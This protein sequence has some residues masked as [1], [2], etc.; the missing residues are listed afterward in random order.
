VT[1]YYA[2]PGIAIYHGDAREVLPT[3]ERGLMVT[4]PPYNVG[5]HYD[6]HE[7]SLQAED[8]RRLLGDVL[9]MPLVVI[10]YPEALV[11]LAQIFRRSADEIVAWVYHAHTPRKWRTVAWFGTAPDLSLM[12][13][14]YRNPTDKRIAWHIANGSDGAS[15]PDWW[16]IEQVK[17][18]SA[19]KTAHPCQIPIEL[20]TRILRVTPTEATIIDPFCGAGS[21]LVAAKALG[22]KA[23]GIELSE[24]YCQ[25]A[26]ERLSQ[27]TLPFEE[28]PQVTERAQGLPL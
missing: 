12:K 16:L 2:E 27:E 8:Y 9:R 25:I 14:P 15:L 11:P 17:N 19:E 22:L 24:R 23:V 20:M 5:Y 7:D 18:V 26:V 6:E 13:Q 4:D 21:T 1:P 3:I 28:G 10:H